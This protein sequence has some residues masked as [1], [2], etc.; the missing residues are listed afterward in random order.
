MFTGITLGSAT[1][2]PVAGWLVPEYGWKIV[3]LIGGVVPLAVAA[4][5]YFVLPES[6]KFLVSRPTRRAE[7]LRTARRMRPDLQIP[8]DAQFVVEAPAAGAGRAQQARARAAF[9]AAAS[10][11][12]RR[13]CGCASPPR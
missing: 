12:S 8:D 13:C 10:R 11:S 9:S 5:L 1:P 4:C 2:G 7:L 3:F 6:V